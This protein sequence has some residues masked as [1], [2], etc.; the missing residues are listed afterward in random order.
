MY[1]PTQPWDRELSGNMCP[2]SNS[3]QLH[4]AIYTLRIFVPRSANVFVCGPS[5]VLGAQA[6]SNYPLLLIGREL[7]NIT[8]LAHPLLS[9]GYQSHCEK[10]GRTVPTFSLR[11]RVPLLGKLKFS[12]QERFNKFSLHKNLKKVILNC[13]K[14]PP[15]FVRDSATS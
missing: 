8:T 14:V 5:R 10:D 12:P 9:P 3:V 11:P 13:K 7:K 4:I 1:K 15:P 6:P 2:F